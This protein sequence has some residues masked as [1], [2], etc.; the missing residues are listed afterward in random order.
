MGKEVQCNVGLEDIKACSLKCSECES[1]I[2]SAIDSAYPW[3]ECCP[4][5][6]ANWHRDSQV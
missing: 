3:P 1:E 5:C 4:M 2:T 6:A